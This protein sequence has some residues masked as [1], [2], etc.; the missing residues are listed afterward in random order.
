MPDVAGDA[1][2]VVTE[3]MLAAGWSAT[4]GEADMYRLWLKN[5]VLTGIYR[6]MRAL[7][8]LQQ[9]AA[10]PT[11]Y[12]VHYDVVRPVT[13]ADVDTWQAVMTAYSALR[14]AVESGHAQLTAEIKTIRSRHGKPH[15]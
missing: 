15:E 1:E 14:R 5:D 13:Q 3:E 7:E 9:S 10:V 2:I 4:V 6:A 8:P 11:A 12:D